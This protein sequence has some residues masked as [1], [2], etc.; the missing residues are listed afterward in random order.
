ML[1]LNLIMNRYPKVGEDVEIIIPMAPSLKGDNIGE[2]VER[3]G[4]YIYIKLKK[5]GVVVENYTCELKPL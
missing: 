1:V 4:E 5:S 3:N 2:V